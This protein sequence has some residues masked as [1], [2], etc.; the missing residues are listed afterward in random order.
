[1]L[2]AHDLS[3]AYCQTVSAYWRGDNEFL[4]QLE[5]WLARFWVGDGPREPV[6]DSLALCPHGA[7]GRGIRW[8]DGGSHVLGY[9][10]GKRGCFDVP[11]NAVL[12]TNS[13][14][15]QTQAISPTMAA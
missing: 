10:P 4:P 1:M 15:G 5:A 11:R 12:P 3:L 8:Y 14:G 2:T 9:V 13:A 6:S 7:K